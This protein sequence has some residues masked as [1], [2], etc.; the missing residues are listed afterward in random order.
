MSA[1]LV[2]YGGDN[3][4]SSAIQLPAISEAKVF[5]E[6]DVNGNLSFPSEAWS[7]NGG[8]VLGLN[9]CGNTKEELVN[10]KVFMD[11][12]KFDMALNE[13]TAI[14]EARAKVDAQK[15]QKVG[16]IWVHR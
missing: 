3:E 13:L 1:A 15:L 4:I 8:M 7:D 6:N 10:L 12:G 9:G 16:K 11:N 2:A 5:S 14:L